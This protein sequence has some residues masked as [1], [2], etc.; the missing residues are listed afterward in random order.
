[1]QE[2]ESQPF[3]WS[4]QA[5]QTAA[6]CLQLEQRGLLLPEPARLGRCLQTP[7]QRSPERG[8]G[9]RSREHQGVPTVVSHGQQK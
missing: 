3:P 6:L 9:Q 4:L 7:W 2:E 1:M 5:G 8:G